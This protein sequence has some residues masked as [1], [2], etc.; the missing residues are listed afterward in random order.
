MLQLVHI[1]KDYFVDKVPFTALKDITLT[2]PDKGLVAILGP[3]GCGKT[4]LLNIIGGLDHY[5]SGD[6]LIDGKSTKEFSDR[7][8]DGYRNERVGFVF[9]SYNLI[10]HE[11]VIQNVEVSLMLNG[12]GKKE[13]EARALAA[14]ESVGLKDEAKKRPNQLSGG[15]MQRVALARALI[16]N[17][18]IVLADEP[19][20][21]LDS[22][23]SVQVLDLFKEVAKDR[24]VIM[25]T[26]NRELAMRYASRIIEMSDGLVM[27]DSDPLTAPEKPLGR[28]IAKKTAMSFL[29]ALKTSFNSILT[30]KGRT[31]LTAVAS[32]IGIIG[33]ALV[34]A[35][36][37]GF[38]NYVDKVEGSVASIVPVSIAPA[39]YDYTSAM[40]AT[41]FTE[42]PTDKNVYIYDTS[43]LAVLAHRNKYDMNYV[44]N[45]LYP[46]VNEGLAR[47]VMVNRRGL[48]FNVLTSA[49]LDETNDDYMTVSQYSSAGSV[50][51]LLSSVSYL[52]ATVMHE[53]YG[54]EK[55]LSSM[56]DVID[57]RFPTSPNE[58][59][60]ITDRYN[61]VEQST[62]KAIGII[63][64]NTPDETKTISFSDFYGKTYRAYA[65]SDFYQATAATTT[66]DDVYTN[67]SIKLNPSAASGSRIT[68]SGTTA[69]KTFGCYSRCDYSSAAYKTLY[70]STTP[71]KDLK[72]VGVLRPS[73]DSYIN[74]M[75]SSL[76]Y[77][78]SLKESFVED[79]TNKCADM[80]FLA[81]NNW[82]LASGNVDTFQKALNS[83]Y[84]LIVTVRDSTSTDATSLGIDTASIE[85]VAKSFSYLY[86]N[87][88][89]S[90]ITAGKGPGYA[91][92]SSF[93][94]NNRMIGSDF[95]ESSVADM[96]ER[97]T[98]T[99]KDKREEAETEFEN[100]I[101]APAFFM[102]H[103][104]TSTDF[105]IQ[106][107]IAYFESYSLIDSILI[108]P[109]SLTTKST[110][111]Q[112]MKDYNN[113]KAKE[114]QIIYSDVMSQFT[115]NL[116]IMI[117]VISTVLIVFASIS[118]VVSSIMMAIITYVSVVERTKE[119]GILRACGARKKDVGRLFE[120]EC[121]IIGFVA[122]AFG[123]AFAYLVCVPVN[124]VIEHLY[125][126]YDANLSGIA[127]LN[128]LHAVFLVLLSVVLALISGF[129]P[130][131]IAAKKD[132]VVA[133]RTE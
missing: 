70:N 122:G 117:Q 106:D 88:T 50:G 103:S 33:V 34:L 57:G 132:P 127:S 100:I 111:L 54:E 47:S 76:G 30:K 125:S 131:R 110:M 120:A 98:S 102:P 75:P 77:L 4:T 2:F 21:A 52:P 19:T 92:Y 6:L 20:G 14:L 123:V 133:L 114:D 24:L 3:S 81:R 56:Y 29:T 61:R 72:I 62:L 8:W 124:S 107:F 58:I 43:S 11:N 35:V 60:L 48:S 101:T 44:N 7:E 104:A 74:L 78:A 82:Y 130:S 85:A 66:K 25:V 16:N 12:V 67:V 41:G 115:D 32:S 129:I 63:N 128:P 31:I 97:L 53:L 64:D 40:S 36:S 38:T 17:P 55:G 37:N 121:V 87:A 23:T 90:D 26:H 71:H 113:G 112:K 89:S 119:I 108:F 93:L 96:V 28:E 84:D 42:Y 83:L 45:V 65:S 68:V 51:S 99:D 73:K 10:P 126:Q 94:Y 22:K 49:G 109:Q 27:K 80:G 13:R 18:K 46:L 1:T 118:L 116:G 86:F 15:Q 79:T 69:S 59:V 91:S 9:Q 95:M 105:N 5:T 39:V